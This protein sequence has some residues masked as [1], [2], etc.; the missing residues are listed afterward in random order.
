MKPRR[1][2]SG[3]YQY[4]FGTPGGITP[5]RQRQEEGFKK[6]DEDKG[7]YQGK[8]FGFHYDE[9]EPAEKKK[10]ADVPGCDPRKWRDA[11]P[12]TP[13]ESM[14]SELLRAERRKNDASETSLND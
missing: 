14:A 11:V 2:T 6:L 4:G 5:E 3:R 9:D 13:E 12:C 1:L 8:C 10:K 7:F